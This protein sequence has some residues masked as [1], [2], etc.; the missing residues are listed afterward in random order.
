MFGCHLAVYAFRQ[1]DSRDAPLGFYDVQT[2]SSA[3][4]EPV[5]SSVRAQIRMGL[6]ALANA[7]SSAVQVRFDPATGRPRNLFS[8]TGRLSGTSDKPAV[9][10]ARSFLLTNNGLFG[11]A[12]AEIAAA[13]VADEYSRP[14]GKSR[15]VVLQQRCSNLDIFQAR[16]QFALDNQGRVIQVAGS[17]HPGLQVAGMARLSPLE[18]IQW[19]AAHCDRAQRRGQPIVPKA[20][21]RLSVLSTRQGM[22]SGN[23]QQMVFESGPFLDPV[24]PRRVV[25]PLGEL[26]IPAWEMTLHVS[27]QEC[28]HVLVDARDGSLLYRTNLYKFAEPGGN[29]RPVGSDAGLLPMVRNGQDGGGVPYRRLILP[30]GLVFT[31]HPDAGPREEV[32]FVGDP[33]ASPVGWCDGTSTTQ[34]NNVVARE[35]VD[36]NNELVP[37]FQPFDR[38]RQFF[39]T[40]TNS[41]ADEH[42][43]GP[44]VN[45]VVTNLFYFCNWYHDY[46]YGLGFNE[47]SGNFQLDNFG[48]GGQGRDRV[49]A[50]AMDGKGFNNSTFLTL[51]DGDPP[52]PYGGHSRLQVFLFKPLPPIYPLYRDGDLDA[53]IV[54]HEYTHGMTA[55]MVGGPSNVLALETLQ[56]ASMAEGWSDFFPCSVFN[57]PV[58]AEYITGNTT[59]GARHGPYNAH[60]WR[61]EFVGRT[62]EVTTPT[63]PAGG[64]LTLVFLPEPHCDGEI[65]A[66]AL[67]ALRTELQSGSLAEQLAVE[68][69]RYTPPSPTMLDGRDAI[70]MADTVRFQGVHH[71]RI[72]RAFAQ[73]GMGWSAEAEIGPNAA[74]VFQA[75]DWPPALGGSFTTGPLVFADNMESVPGEESGWRTM[76]G[77][78][79]AFHTTKHRSASGASSWYFGQE[80]VWNYNTGRREWSSLESPPI[81]LASGSGYLLEF[82]H[83]RKAED[84][85]HWDVPPHYFDPGIIYIHMAGTNEYYEMGFSFHNTRGWETRRIDLSDF[86]GRTL[87]VGFYFDTW[88]ELNNTFEGWYIDDVKVIESQTANNSPTAAR[89]RWNAYR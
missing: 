70:L 80:T 40:F 44:D 22:A 79:V 71:A 10:I 11:L 61:F 14:D 35:D 42:T 66:A 1:P 45:A 68:A 78:Q 49:Y 55:R 64:P 32:S 30:A 24:L 36:G 88:D 87:H 28:Y 57:D 39:Y 81:T 56:A 9:E 26:G 43:T 74:L 21:L 86:A 60:P 27:A 67:W 4:L 85:I 82:K 54:L 33:Y 73:R 3:A 15:H 58:I 5:E 63:L 47:A 12:P 89:P 37:G 20:A 41:W 50:D 65:W 69:L 59:H 7:T 84:S 53:D 83:W 18:A 62:F 8:L 46:L 16:I 23:E 38:Y 2:Q 72:W 17:Y 51:P 29:Q 77:G 75:F 76:A 52:G 25:M 31:E 48:R 34:G 13:I 6:T 19:A